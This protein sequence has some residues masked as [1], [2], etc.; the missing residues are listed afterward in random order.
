M[1]K[2]KYDYNAGGDEIDEIKNNTDK[3]DDRNVKSNTSTIVNS[4]DSDNKDGNKSVNIELNITRIFLW[5]FSNHFTFT[6]TV[7]IVGS[8][9]GAIGYARSKNITIIPP[10][11][12]GLFSNPGP[13]VWAISITSLGLIAIII[14]LYLM[15]NRFF[16]SIKPIRDFYTQVSRL[17]FKNAI[18]QI[19]EKIDEIQFYIKDNINTNITDSLKETTESTHKIFGILVTISNAVKGL[20]DV[21]RLKEM[22]S[23]RTKLLFSDI[24]QV[25]INTDYFSFLLIAPIAPMM[26]QDPSYNRIFCK[27]AFAEERLNASIELVKK[28]YI[29]DV[30]KIIAAKLTESQ[31][32]VI[33]QYLDDQLEI[34]HKLIVNISLLEGSDGQQVSSSERP[35][36][37]MLLYNINKQISIMDVELT[38]IFNSVIFTDHIYTKRSTEKE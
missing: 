18:Y 30:E 21:G 36:I 34:I 38:N 29:T 3:I 4:V 15:S 28:N 24:I 2:L 7:L 9:I 26:A 14:S 12:I 33:S 35:T 23:I 22:L 10:E 5:L 6:S 13:S 25:T 16:A 27:K 17:N 31:R 32:T 11:I 8:I 19:E 20:P 1:S 37:D